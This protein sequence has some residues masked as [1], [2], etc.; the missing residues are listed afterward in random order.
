VAVL[1][2][3]AET[4]AGPLQLELEWP[5]H[6]VVYEN[7]TTARSAVLEFKFENQEYFDQW[8]DWNYGPF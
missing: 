1:R 6:N 3:R 2:V 8:I 7:F 5:M 4:N